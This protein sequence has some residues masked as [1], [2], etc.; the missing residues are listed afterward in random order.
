MYEKEKAE[1]IKKALLLV[2]KLA[3]LDVD[4]DIDEIE[5]LIDEAKKMKKNT[6]F[7]LK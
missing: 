4:D 6:L 5:E 7:R 3:K 1:L 2:D